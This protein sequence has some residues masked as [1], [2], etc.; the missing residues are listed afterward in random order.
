MGNSNPGQGLELR[1]QSLLYKFFIGNRNSVPAGI[2]EISRESDR[3]VD[4]RHA[5][6]AVAEG[7]A[8]GAIEGL[9]RPGRVDTGVA[10]YQNEQATHIASVRSL[11]AL[12][13]YRVVDCHYYVKPGFG[14]NPRDTAVIVLSL[15]QRGEGIELSKETLSGLRKLA[16]ENRWTT[17]V[18]DNGSERPSTINFTS[19][20]QVRPEKMM[21]MRDGFLRLVPVEGND[22]WVIEREEDSRIALDLLDQLERLKKVLPQ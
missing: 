9:V 13:G 18:W 22:A 12:R 8:R 1:G 3:K 14:R 16:R 15:S 10:I 20:T 2:R 5:G 6:E 17:H 19:R 21:V 7:N 4:Q 11:L